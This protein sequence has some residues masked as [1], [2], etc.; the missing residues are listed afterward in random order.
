MELLWVDVVFRGGF[1]DGSGNEQIFSMTIGSPP[2]TTSSKAFQWDSPLT[3]M[4]VRMVGRG[5]GGL[6]PGVEPFRYNFQSK[7]GYGYL[8]AS[9]AF[10][11]NSFSILVQ[12]GQV[13]NW[14]LFYRFIDIPLSEFIGL[15][16][17]TQQI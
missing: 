1:A 2:Q 9:D 16:Q 17:S 13:Y 10:N 7:D 8:L 4:M 15:V 5:T 11:V 12:S 6:K 3:F 14:K